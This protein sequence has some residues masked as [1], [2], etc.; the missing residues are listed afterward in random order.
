MFSF[1]PIHPL[2]TMKHHPQFQ[3]TQHNT[4]RPEFQ[5]ARVAILPPSR[6]YHIC[7]LFTWKRQAAQGKKK[8]RPLSLQEPKTPRVA[9]LSSHRV[10]QT[11][12]F[13]F[14]YKCKSKSKSNLYQTA[15]FIR[16][17][18]LIL[19]SLN[20]FYI[21]SL[22]RPTVSYPFSSRLL[23]LSLTICYLYIS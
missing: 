13:Q 10:Y 5:R 21:F 22:S 2:G 9:Y 8:I 3:P 1:I 16:P 20:T 23:V 12:H 7:I 14:A 15:H 17:F 4:T 11:T 19:E 18:F 6:R